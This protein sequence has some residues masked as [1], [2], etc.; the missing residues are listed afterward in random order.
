MNMKQT[1]AHTWI[2]VDKDPGRLNF[3]DNFD[4]LTF[5]HHEFKRVPNPPKEK[6]DFYRTVLKSSSNKF[7][8]KNSKFCKACG[9]ESQD[10][11]SMAMIWACNFIGLYEEQGKDIEN[12]KKLHHYLAQRFYQYRHY[13]EKRNLSLGLAGDKKAEFSEVH[14]DSSVPSYEETRIPSDQE[15]L[16]APKDQ[17]IEAMV[18]MKNQLPHSEFIKKLL[19]ATNNKHLKSKEKKKM[20]CKINDYVSRY[21]VQLEA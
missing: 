13:M 20:H 14:D 9:I 4:D 18:K 8:N 11:L 16:V 2:R 7:L 17:L 6:F 12:K 21:A 1:T 3:H 5:R 19:L 10:L 15:L